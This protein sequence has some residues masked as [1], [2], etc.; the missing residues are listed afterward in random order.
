MCLHFHSHGVA[1]VNS[2]ATMARL[3]CVGSPTSTSL[4][5]GARHLRWR[6]PRADFT[7]TELAHRNETI[8]SSGQ[9]HTWNIFANN[10]RCISCSEAGIAAAPW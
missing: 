3:P 5:R 6:I 9:R 4:T 7:C 8:A 2:C 10:K 1:G